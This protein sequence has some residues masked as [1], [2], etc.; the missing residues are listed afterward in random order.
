MWGLLHM[1]GGLVVVDGGVL[2]GPRSYRSF[3]ASISSCTRLGSGPRRSRFGRCWRPSSLRRIADDRRSR[4]S[5][6]WAPGRS[7]RCSSSRASQVFDATNVG[8]TS[9]P[10]GTSSSTCLEAR[11]RRPGC[12]HGDPTAAA[13]RVRQHGRDRGRPLTHLEKD[14]WPGKRGHEAAVRRVLRRGPPRASAPAP[15]PGAQPDPLPRRGRSRL[16]PEGPSEV[17][18]VVGE[19]RPDVRPLGEAARALPLCNDRP[20]RRARRARPPGQLLPISGNDHHARS[21]TIRH[22]SSSQQPNRQSTNQADH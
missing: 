20:A 8:V 5:G 9:T 12:R 3:C 18:A 10:A 17:R 2:Y 1:A 6:A 13:M 21:R 16:L 11:S 19:E 22:A 4:R 7:T 15:R 14:L